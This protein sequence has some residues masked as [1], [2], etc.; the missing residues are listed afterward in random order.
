MLTLVLSN[1][2]V[3]SLGLESKL[4]HLAI[5]QYILL[6]DYDKSSEQKGY[7]NKEA[8]DNNIN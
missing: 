1:T 4:I 5:Q 8:Q 6:L 7:I 3:G 2:V